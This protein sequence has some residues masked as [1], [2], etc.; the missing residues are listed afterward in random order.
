MLAYIL[1]KSLH[2]TTNSKYNLSY[3]TQILQQRISG[4]T[5]K[6][7]T[8]LGRSLGVEAVGYP[9]LTKPALEIKKKEK[10][11]KT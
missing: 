10:K 4:E 9:V 2:P 8:F 7:D 5:G 1:R 3:E 11:N 6:K